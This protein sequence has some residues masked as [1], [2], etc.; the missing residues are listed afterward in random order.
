MSQLDKTK[1]MIKKSIAYIL[2]LL[3]L[4]GLIPQSVFATEN[5]P[6]K[7]QEDI[8]KQSEEFDRRQKENQTKE[9]TPSEEKETHQKADNETD[10]SDVKKEKTTGVSVKRE[11]TLDEELPEIDGTLVEESGNSATY[12]VGKNEYITRITDEPLTY[13][14]ENG[15]EKQV[16][17]DLVK[18]GDHYTNKAG[19]YDIHLPKE[20]SSIAIEQEDTS[21][22]MAPDF[23][24]LK[25]EVVLENAI[26]YNNVAKNID[27]QYTTHGDYVKEDIILNKPAELKE[28]RYILEGR[29]LKYRIKDNQL[30]AYRN[31]QYSTVFTIDAPYMIDNA[32]EQSLGITLALTEEDGKQVLTVT[33]DQEWLSAPQRAYPVTIDPKINLTKSKLVCNMVENGVD[34]SG[35][36]HAGPDVDHTGVSYLYAGYERGNMTGVPSITYKNTRSYLRIK[37]NFTKIQENATIKKAELKAF[38]YAGNPA[39]GSKVYCDMVLDDWKSDS[40]R[41]WNTKPTNFKKI[42]DGQDVSGG[43]K[44]VTW[45]IKTAVKAWA[46]G[47]KNYGLVLRPEKEDQDAVCFSGPGNQHGEHKMYLDL[48]WTV[49]EEVDQDYPLKAPVINLRPLTS[50]PGNRQALKGVLADGVVRPELDVDYRLNNGQKGTYKGAEYGKVY[51]NSN[52]V[53][54]QVSFEKGYT[55]YTDSNWQ[56][57]A[58]KSFSY[59][60]PYR[61]YAKASDD[62]NTT[63]EGKSDEFIVYKFKKK[64]TLPYVAKFYGVKVKQLV[65]DNRPVDYLCY[66][67]S[68]IFIRSPKK[69]KTKNYTREAKL[70]KK[71]RKA[72][73]KANLGRGK[74]AAFDL[75]PINTSLG[76]YYFESVDAENTEFNGDFAL[77]RSYNSMGDQ[78][79]GIFGEGWNFE[80]EQNLTGDE[81]GS[82]TW[83]MGDGKEIIFPQ[84]GTG[85]GS[86]DGYYMELKKIESSELE[87]TYYEIRD[88]QEKKLY[89]FNSYGLLTKITDEKGLETKLELNEDGLIQKLTTGSGRVYH[90]AISED[91][92]ATAITLPNGG[93]L[94]YGYNVDGYMTSYTN[95]DGDQVSYYYDANGYMTS[96]TDGNGK[97]V[98]ENTYDEYGRVLKQKDANG[99]VSDI[100]YEDDET[101]ITDAEGNESIYGFDEDYK[102]TDMEIAGTEAKQEYDEDYNLISQTDEEG[103]TIRYEYD[104]QGKV[105]KETRS[106][107]ASRQSRYDAEGNVIWEQDFNGN[108]TESVYDAD[109]NL[110]SQTGPTGIKVSYTYDGYGR[111]TSQTDGEGNTTHYTYDGLSKMTETDPKGN[112]TVSYYDAMGNLI[113]EVDPEGVENKNMYTK[114]GKNSGTWQTGGAGETYGYDR[115][116]NCTSITDSEGATTTFSYDAMGNMTCVKG[117]DGSMLSYT[118][119]ALGHKTSE[120]DSRGNKTHYQYDKFGNLTEETDAQGNVKTYEYDGLSQLTKETNAKGGETVYEYDDN[121]GQIIKQTGPEGTEKFDYDSEGNLLSSV[122]GKGGKS[123]FSYDAIGNI[124][125]ETQPSGL[126]IHYTYDKN[127][128]LIQK[129]DSAGRTITFQYDELGNMVS[130]TDELG[131]ETQYIYDK[132]GKLIQE[133]GPDGRTSKYEYDGAGNIIKETDAE[134]NVT[135]MTYD[136]LGN[137]T[138]Q[139]D[140]RGNVTRYTYDAMGNLRKTI[141]AVGNE[142]NYTYNE[143]EMPVSETDR[144]GNTTRYEYDSLHQITKVIDPLGNAVTTTYDELGGEKRINSPDG[145]FEENTYDK[146]GNLIK[147]ADKEGL[148][149]QYEYDKAGQLIREWDNAGNETAYAYDLSG[150]MI[151]QTDSAGRTA[152]YIYDAAGDLIKEIS[153]DG[154]VT[155]YAYDKKGQLISTT[156]NAGNKTTFTYDCAGNVITETDQAKRTWTY[157]YDRLD[158]LKKETDPLGQT[159]SHTYDAAGN[160][161]KTENPDGTAV[162]YLYDKLDQLTGE[163]DEAG[164]KNTYT[165]DREGQLIQETDKEGGSTEYLYDAAGNVISTKDAN[166]AVTKTEYTKTGKIK[167]VIYPRGGKEAYTYDTHGNVLTEKSAAGAVTSYT[168]DKDDKLLRQK[169]PNGLLYEYAYDR[170]GR[171]TEIKDSMGAQSGLTYD[172]KGNVSQEKR[173]N[174][175]VIRYNYDKLHQVTRI[176]NEKGAVT[177]YAYDEAG[178]LASE[179][180]PSGAKTSYTYDKLDRIKTIKESMLAKVEYTY[181]KAGNLTKVKQKD[182]NETYAY[183]NTGNQIR[184]VSPGG[185]TEEFSYDKNGEMTGERNGK[186]QQTKMAYDAMGRLRQTIDAKGNV[187]KTDYD[188]E[189]N[190]IK[191][192]DP[193]GNSMSYGYDLGGRMVRVTDPLKNTTSYTYD[194]M[195]NLTAVTDAA[196]N[197]TRYK[198]DLHGNLTRVTTPEGKVEQFKYDV[199]DRLISKTRPDGSR[200][201]YNYDKLNSLV[202]KSYSDGSKG[203]VYGYDKAGNKISMK[204]ESGKSKYT[205]DKLDRLKTVTDGQGKTIS[206]YYDEYDRISKITYPDGRKVSYQYDLDDNLTKVSDSRGLTVK[207]R[208]DKNN[209]VISCSRSD[210]TVTTYKYDELDQ[211]I[212]LVNRKGKKNLSSFSYTYDANGRITKETALQDSKKETR[213]YTYDKAGQL[214]GCAEKKG[215]KTE[216]TR[217]TYNSSGD[218]IAVTEGKETIVTRYNDD[219]Q[220]TSRTNKT[221]GETIRYTYDKNGNLIAKKENG[222]KTTYKYDA[223]DRLRAVSSGGQVLMS[224]TYDGEDNKVFQ[225]TRKI[226]STEGSTGSTAAASLQADKE[227]EEDDESDSTAGK[228]NSEQGGTSGKASQSWFDPDIFGY[229]FIQGLAKSCANLNQGLA[230]GIGDKIRELWTGKTAYNTD[231]TANGTVAGD[232]GSD[233][234]ERIEDVIVP[235]A[236][237]DYLSTIVIPGTDPGTAVTYDLTYYVNDVNTEYAQTLME[238]GKDGKVKAA[239]TYGNERLTADFTGEGAAYSGEQAGLSTYLYDGK[240][241]V[242]QNMDSGAGTITRSL[243][244]D[245]FG[246]ITEGAEENDVLYGYNGEEHIQNVNLQYLRDRYYDPQTG[247]FVSQDD[248]LGETD[249]PITQNRYAYGDNDPVN[250]YD[251]SGNWSLKKLFNKGKRKAKQVGSAIKRGAG[252]AVNTLRSGYT[253]VK[254]KI[255]SYNRRSSSKPPTPPKP[256]ARTFKGRSKS[257]VPSYRSYNRKLTKS[258]HEYKKDTKNGKKFK[259]PKTSSSDGSGSKGDKSKKDK[260]KKASGKKK[261][262]GCGGSGKKG[263]A[264][265]STKGFLTGFVNYLKT[266]GKNW[267]KN[268]DARAYKAFKTGGVDNWAD[269]L[270]FGIVGAGKNYFK[271][272][273][274]RWK[275]FKKKPTVY[276]AL[277]WLSFGTL[278][279]GRTYLTSKPGS[280]AWWDSFFGIAG[281]IIGAKYVKGKGGKVRIRSHKAKTTVKVS[282]NKLKHIINEHKPGKYAQTLAHK[283][284]QMVEDEL[285]GGNHGKSFFP[286]KWSNETIEKAVNYGYKKAIKKG[287]VNGDYNFKYKGEIITIHFRKGEI[288]TAYGHYRYTYEDLLK[289]QGGK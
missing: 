280:Y 286:P 237:T 55:G 34:T 153:F 19:S 206:Y 266:K 173:E 171:I 60:T 125:T 224:A 258:Y 264:A 15:K 92:L 193:M 24:K 90:F 174:G 137:M 142:T 227:G 191:V 140:A 168:Y 215:G 234:P 13:K 211:L 56:S 155:E 179:L 28:F 59:A 269:Y 20:G 30:Q 184:T 113:N 81:D 3:L 126:K 221:T 67:G 36:G 74:C 145:G 205:Y 201:K 147:T 144:N 120:T 268:A 202:G 94:S 99:G 287:K 61:V 259:K 172:R 243:R 68:T 75:E 33:P 209:N 200:I 249:D 119:D 220:I 104:Q 124:L 242:A 108:I 89:T 204:D 98:V 247:S 156:D 163:I 154:D 183:D 187:T 170:A 152:S 181:D 265:A 44:W 32:G 127:R 165:Y 41:T 253:S 26:R 267:Y 78:S 182:K 123:A 277:N 8:K 236:E 256:P 229:G 257:T 186:G 232:A 66:A 146:Y 217:Y 122:D 72:L 222:E 261:S 164:N 192:T 70:S 254:K 38:K 180:S 49:P 37:Y 50:N 245:V 117:P 76:N 128:N 223:E 251:P 226:V 188:E 129:T 176:V 131:N 231:G 274:A 88:L 12:Q 177:S 279:L 283:P 203:T 197:S 208:Y 218:K 2:I 216:K 244:Y 185:R 160:L 255:S 118:Y 77:T 54:D 284:R 159:S 95:A 35:K 64:D 162:S 63:P 281:I 39:S 17:N 199:A 260:G 263:G 116:G 134:G 239:Y 166:G 250:N 210:G 85:W 235:G 194:D 196:G 246:E 93:V 121:T 51:P 114:G 25:D 52:L 167:E 101:Q 16:E 21:F 212:Q 57:H 132:A 150:N 143:A 9:T 248:Y 73:V 18:A 83:K 136:T 133:T 110:L 225:M 272:N 91:G 62:E 65:K 48:N 1:K 289:M 23:G 97:K 207:Y 161:I 100:T 149:T 262:Y 151:S 96:W 84:S 43:D 14:D 47:D 273:A 240:G 31:E 138:S 190:L 86:P 109:S 214:T 6:E 22:K 79:S 106:D 233:D 27:L 46:K 285:N 82:M 288:Q 157:A 135:K 7:I 275:A 5:S 139:T 42:D 219:H 87:N 178:N 278:D 230:Y 158:Q 11:P 10:I 228:G 29:G 141:D 175:G 45:N 40:N 107:G 189:G 241:N 111:M 195:D 71:H 80:Y 112:Q 69:N 252:N 115:T 169:E 4:T 130:E 213:I 238:Y 103:N 276:N 105:T 53:K 270:T 58:F 102:T 148:I 198:Y 282:K 271:N